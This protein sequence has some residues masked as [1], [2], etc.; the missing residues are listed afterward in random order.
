M[1]ERLADS[2]L[3]IGQVYPLASE[4]SDGKTVS[5]GNH[6][7]SVHVLDKFDFNQVQLCF[8]CVPAEV[9]EEF[10]DKASSAGCYSIDFSTYSRLRSEIPLLVAGVNNDRLQELAGKVVASPDSSVIHLAQ[11]LAPMTQLTVIERIN[12]VLL[13]AVSEV[14]RAGIQ[15]LSEQSIALFNLKPIVSKLPQ[16]CR[17]RLCN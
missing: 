10:I 5:Y 8:F 9:S 13:R 14:G 2:E 12:A 6:Q 4:R 1:L 16:K 11:I 7:L 15:E 3:P 17:Q